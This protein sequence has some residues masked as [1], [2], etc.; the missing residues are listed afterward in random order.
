MTCTVSQDLQLALLLGHMHEHGVHYT[1]ETIDAAGAVIDTVYSE[2]WMPSYSS[3]PPILKF[4]MEAPLTFKAGTRFR[5]T[6]EWN[7]D[8]DKTLIFPTEMCV[9][10]G[11]YFPG[12]NRL[13]CDKDVTP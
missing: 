4:T 3:H 7:N 8:T 2:D 9:G 13:Q 11:Y 12:E 1:L 6:C 5:Q 10:F